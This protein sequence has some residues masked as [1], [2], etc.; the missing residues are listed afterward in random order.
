MATKTDAPTIAQDRGLLLWWEDFYLPIFEY[1]LN[2]IGD[3]NGKRVLELGC[4]EG[5]T[6]VLLAKRGASVFGIDLLDFRLDAARERAVQHKVTDAV[7]FALMDGMQLGFNDNTFDLVISKSVLVFTDHAVIARECYRV[8]KPEG[9]AI[10]I[11][12][13]QNHPAV[14]LYRKFFLRYSS[15]LRYFSMVDVEKMRQYFDHMQHRE[16]HIL[17]MGALIWQKVF[18]LKSLYQITLR[19]LGACDKRLLKW[20]PRLNRFCWITAMICHKQNT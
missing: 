17:A 2:E 14:Q 20:F 16:F 5:G 11:E 10:F 19:G 8:L 1:V 4:G 3:L 15:D 12:N 9:K 18:G 6:S 13:M 7:Q